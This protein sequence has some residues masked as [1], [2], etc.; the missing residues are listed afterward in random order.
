VRQI[1][2][3]GINLFQLI[4]ILIR[5]YEERSGQ[6]ALNLS[7]G[8]PDLVPPKEV[9]ALK[10]R[11]AGDAALDYQTYAE[12]KSLHLFAERMT[13]I[14]SVGVR[15]SEHP[16]L[17]ALPTNGIKSTTALL[18]LACGLHLR[19][20]EGRPFVVASHVP[21][22]DVIG[23]WSAQY[24]GADRVEWA[25]DPSTG[26][27]IDV[28]SLRGAVGATRKPNLVFVIRPGNPASTGASRDEW[29]S[30]IDYCLETGARLVNDAAYTTLRDPASDR[31]VPLA[32]VAKDY[33]ALEW[34]ELYSVSKATSDPGAR[35]GAAL[36][37]TDFIEDLRLIKGNTDSG[38]NP[39]VMA[40]YGELFGNRDLTDRLLRETHETYRRRLDYLI[41]AL[42]G[43][44][45]TPACE[46]SAGFF[47]LWNLPRSVFGVS[48]SAEAN[49]RGCSLGE[50][51]NRLVIDRTGIV[52]VHF[53]RY[54]RYAVCTD[55]LAPA[56]RERFEK[57]LATW[58]LEA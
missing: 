39:G 26:M 48:L 45:L 28:K 34:M 8:N 53:D 12:D 29:R 51:F 47:T 23:T 6:R 19:R 2:A 40:A 58:R 25:L 21:A 14:F 43:A 54:I 5:E 20:K 31:H 7:L 1:P 49:R 13:E 30:L 16:G 33:P 32:Q 24:L 57:S 44:G 18:P 3:S 35:L 22:Y 50:A 15:V 17:R 56:F 11:Y 38:P 36:G 10:A 9:L 46:T 37:S 55:V 42:R 41:P 4:Y 52:G 27:R